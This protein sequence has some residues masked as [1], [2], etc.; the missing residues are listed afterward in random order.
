[1]TFWITKSVLYAL[2]DDGIDGILDITRYAFMLKA[3]VWVFY[4]FFK[5]GV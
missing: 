1:M 4:S 2:Q 5:Y 3:I